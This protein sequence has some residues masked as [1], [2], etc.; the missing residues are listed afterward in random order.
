MAVSAEA[1]VATA[2]VTVGHSFSSFGY[3]PKLVLIDLFRRNEMVFGVRQKKIKKT[4]TALRR[5]FWFWQ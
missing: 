1:V 2:T 5:W 3:N 4:H